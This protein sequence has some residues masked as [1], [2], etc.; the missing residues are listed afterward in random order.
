M[1]KDDLQRIESFADTL[2][3]EGEGV[4]KTSFH[5]MYG[6][7]VES[8]TFHMFAGRCRALLNIAGEQ[9]AP[10][11]DMLIPE[12][13]HSTLTCA[14]RMVGAVSAIRDAV[15]EGLLL[16]VEDLVRAD[17]FADF[18]EMAEYLLRE[19]YKDPAAVI[20]GGVLEEHLRKLCDKNAIAPA[21]VDGKPKKASLLNDDLAKAKAYEKLEQKNVTA[22]LDLRNKAAHGRYSEYEASHVDDMLR[23]V[24]NFLTRCRV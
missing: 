10:W 20:I 12:E 11:R 23:S 19:G 3:R 17:L 9:A 14:Q 13:H 16:Q 22:W 7:W 5:N 15:K 4:L 8:E 24:R 1:R 18:L 2:V 6:W 21:D